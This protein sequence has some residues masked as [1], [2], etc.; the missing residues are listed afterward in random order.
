LWNYLSVPCVVRVGIPF[1]EFYKRPYPYCSCGI[2]VHCKIM[3]IFVVR[4][5]A[6]PS[7]VYTI[8]E[9]PKRASFHCSL[10]WY[11]KGIVYQQIIVS[12]H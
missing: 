11:A 3:R 9:L 4:S 8:S 6:I 2:E 12:T 5:I 7:I 10:L 1:T